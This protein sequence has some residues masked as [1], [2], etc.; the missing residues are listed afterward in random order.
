MEKGNT[1]SLATTRS[2]SYIDDPSATYQAG[3]LLREPL[4]KDQSSGG[5][6]V[7]VMRLTS[8]GS[9][10]EGGDH[11]DGLSGGHG[12]GLRSGGELE[13]L[14]AFQSSAVLS[15]KLSFGDGSAPSERVTSQL[16]MAKSSTVPSFGCGHGETDIQWA[17]LIV[18][19]PTGE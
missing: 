14:V 12:D 13:L 19:Q 8:S 18:N 17:T 3:L 5:A 7:S 4:P 16:I 2:P 6:P 11:G 15:L 1:K 10:E 9:D